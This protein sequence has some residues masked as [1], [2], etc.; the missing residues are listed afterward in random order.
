MHGR[1]LYQYALNH[2]PRAIQACLNKMVP[3]GD[4]KVLIHQANG[5]M[6]DAI[7]NR[8]YKLEGDLPVP[9]DV[10]PMTISWLG[11]SSVATIQ[12]CSI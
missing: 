10:M 9:H 7:L 8:L 1:K 11:N 5:K 6:D 2:V 12:L 4:I 3:L